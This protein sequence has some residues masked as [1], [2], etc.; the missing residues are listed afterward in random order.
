MGTKERIRELV[1][2][3]T[4]RHVL[5]IETFS[6]NTSTAVQVLLEGDKYK[7]QFLLAPEQFPMTISGPRPAL[8]AL[9]LEEVQ[10]SSW[11]PKKVVR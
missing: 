6:D 2:S 11:P 3:Y 10:F 4:G 1:E 8:T 7:K 9:E 5:E